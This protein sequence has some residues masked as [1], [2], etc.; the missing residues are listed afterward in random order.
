MW[1]TAGL[2]GLTIVLVCL[3]VGLC[4]WGLHQYLLTVVGA[5][6]AGLV[7]GLLAFSI[8]GVTGWLAHRTIR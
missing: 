4:L 2:I 7:V 1:W 3:G 6:P 5:G 8:A